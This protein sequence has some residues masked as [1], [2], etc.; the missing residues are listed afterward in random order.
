VFTS[1]STASP[2]RIGQIFCVSLI[3]SLAD[4]ALRLSLSPPPPPLSLSLSLSLS[5][6]RRAR[7]AESFR[8]RTAVSQSRPIPT[9]Y[10]NGLHR[11]RGLLTVRYNVTRA[12][13]PRAECGTRYRIRKPLK[14][15][16]GKIAR[17]PAE[18]ISDMIAIHKTRRYV[19]RHERVHVSLADAGFL[20]LSSPRF[21]SHRTSEREDEISI[22]FRSLLASPRER[23]RLI[24]LTPR[25]GGYT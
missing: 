3:C 18:I 5:C 13:E 7:I 8:L 9:N 10:R 22:P 24:R 21:A 19:G 6:S 1:L 15:Q 12:A 14:I 2:A 17:T 16:R 23:A 20:S 11:N 4:Y 25:R